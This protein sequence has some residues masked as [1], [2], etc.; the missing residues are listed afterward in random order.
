MSRWIAAALVVCCCVAPLRAQDLKE[1]PGTIVT[2]SDTFFRAL[3]DPAT[4]PDRAFRDLLTN[5]PLEN[6][7][8]EIKKLTDRYRKLQQQFGRFTE[9]ERLGARAAGAGL[10]QIRCVHRPDK[11][12]GVWWITYYRPPAA[13]AMELPEW[14]VVAVRFDSRA[15]AAF[16]PWTDFVA[17]R[18]VAI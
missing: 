5:G 17:A 7:A 1:I 9:F 15:D 8:E 18:T 2:R 10:I 12:P 11:Q 4:D 3:G 13:G 16:G 14:F 6:R